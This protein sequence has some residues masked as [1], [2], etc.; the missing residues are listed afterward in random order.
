MAVSSFSCGIPLIFIWRQS[1]GKP[2]A[3]CLQNACGLEKKE[4]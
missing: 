4:E 1:Y 3:T 2:F